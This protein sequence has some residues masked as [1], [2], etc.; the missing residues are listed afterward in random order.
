[1]AALRRAGL[2]RGRGG[3]RRARPVYDAAR[4]SGAVRLPSQEPVSTE[5]RPLAFVPRAVWLALGVALAAQVAWNAALPAKR[6]AASD[7]PAAPSPALLRLAS[8]GEPEAA[9]R[10]AMLYLQSFDYGGANELRY[11]ELDYARLVQ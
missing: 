7:L 1:M 11:R 9:A 6:P 3:D 8:F 2:R 5:E 10:L 4:R